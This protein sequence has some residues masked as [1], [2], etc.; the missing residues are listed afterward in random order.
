MARSYS[1][2]VIGG[3][4]Y[5]VNDPNIAPVF[6]T[7]VAYSAGEHVKH[8]GI[9]Y[10][11]TSDHPAG[12][13]VTT[14]CVQVNV[15]EEVSSLKSA[16]NVL[17]EDLKPYEVDSYP[18]SS[19]VWNSG[20]IDKDGNVVSGSVKYSDPIPV[21]GEFIEIITQ[22]N[23][24]L[25]LIWYDDNDNEIIRYRMLFGKGTH[26]FV[27]PSNAVSLVFNNMGTAWEYSSLLIYSQATGSTEKINSNSLN[28]REIIDKAGFEIPENKNLYDERFLIKGA[29]IAVGDNIVDYIG[30]TGTSNN[31]ILFFKVQ[32]GKTYTVTNGTT[33]IQLANSG[34]LCDKNFNALVY[35]NS[36]PTY[37][38]SSGYTANNDNGKY[39][40]VECSDN[41]DDQTYCYVGILTGKNI[42]DTYL[43]IREGT[44]FEYAGYEP[45][46]D[47]PG[48]ITSPDLMVSD[49]NIDPVLRNKIGHLVTDTSLKAAVATS[50]YYYNREIG[51]NPSSDFIVGNAI[52]LFNSVKYIDE[53][54]A[55]KLQLSTYFSHTPTIKKVGTKLYCIYEENKLNNY[56]APWPDTASGASLTI[57]LAIIDIET[58][59]IDSNVV[60]IKNGDSI[61]N[62][63]IN[64]GVGDPNMY[65]VSDSV[66]R[67]T[68]S[69]HTSDD[70]WRIVYRDY[71]ISTGEYSDIGKCNLVVNGTNYEF[72]TET[73]TDEITDIQWSG[74][75]YMGSQY[76]TYNGYNYII[77]GEE[78]S[79]PTGVIL[80]T[81]DFITFEYW[82]TPS[83]Q[84]VN[85]KYEGVCGYMSVNS[86]PT[87]FIAY[88]LAI[89]TQM[90]ICRIN[91][92]NKNNIG[93]PV[94]IEDTGSRS[95]WIYPSGRNLY[96]M[97]SHNT[98]YTI[99]IDN[100]N[101]YDA[102]IKN[103]CQGYEATYPSVLRDDDDY[104]I[105]Y[106]AV[107]NRVSVSKFKLHYDRNNVIPMMAKLLDAVEG[108]LT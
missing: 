64:T 49:Q 61:G 14:D 31:W 16:L 103:I 15:G 25:Y 71:N 79:L 62:L 54:T 78:T 52:S 44:N 38:I 17:E 89:G 37:H 43:C 47:N 87:L 28:C 108:K 72:T 85:M 32:K 80:R 1:K 46:S 65:V 27:V 13:F 90:A 94:F 86:V 57:N 105:G 95:A 34:W 88:R 23:D 30:K 104:Y 98:R 11:F 66:I 75:F 9:L 6:S 93:S 106:R 20:Y 2:Q 26:R 92:S 4:D 91:L 69:T 19:V 77:V 5:I 41:F 50:G 99:A 101:I 39:S 67:L 35:A 102:S 24:H 70:K 48:Y 74:M 53:V 55:T 100:V 29:T 107:G 40:T 7:G 84:N 56:D 3:T 96:L 51:G 83:I 82:H 22:K 33:G 21:S 68:G 10:R 76:A 73:V 36:L 12:A 45:P 42:D 58:W 18:F 97:H 59:T 60:A 8:E 63:T 81:A